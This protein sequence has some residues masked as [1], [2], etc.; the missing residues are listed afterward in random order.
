MMAEL[1]RRLGAHHGQTPADLAEQAVRGINRT[2]FADWIQSEPKPKD[3]TTPTIKVFEG[4][5]DPLNQIYQ[6][7]QKM[8]LETRNEA[9]ICKVFSTTLAGP[10]LLWFRQIPECSIN[11]FEDFCKMFLKQYAGARRQ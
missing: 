9:I 2:A 5:T 4:K 8:A 11:G 1:S 10:A 7:Q 3:F 6:F